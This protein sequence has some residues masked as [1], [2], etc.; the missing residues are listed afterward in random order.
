MG[1]NIQRQAEPGNDRSY[2]FEGLPPGS[3]TLL[4]YGNSRLIGKPVKVL[5]KT[6]VR[7]LVQDI[8]GD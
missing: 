6:G 8:D 7:E 3:Y 2:L 1:K 4:H 5:I